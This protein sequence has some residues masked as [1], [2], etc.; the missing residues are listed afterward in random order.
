MS[1]SAP[2]LLAEPTCELRPLVLSRGRPFAAV[3][4]GAAAVTG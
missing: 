1:G 4:P 2:L 3:A